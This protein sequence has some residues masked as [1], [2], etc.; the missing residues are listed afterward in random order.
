MKKIKANKINNETIM[1]KNELKSLILIIVIVSTIF[2]VFYGITL[3]TSKTKTNGTTFEVQSETIQYDEIIIGQVL[4]RNKKEYYVL[5][6]DENNNYN[7][8]YLYYLKNYVSK[9]ENKKYYT[10]DLNSEFNSAYFTDVE[11]N[12]NTKKFFSSKFSDTTL[13]LVKNKKISKFYTTH[14]EIVSILSKINS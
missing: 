11:T 2:L 10:V 5:L 7:D 8:L 1:E 3:L 4:N 12:V 14:E 9:N 13:L 6:M